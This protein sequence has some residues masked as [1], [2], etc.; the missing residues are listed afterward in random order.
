MLHLYLFLDEP[1]PRPLLSASPLAHGTALLMGIH[2][3]REE[4]EAHLQRLREQI[5]QALGGDGEC[6]SA[7]KPLAEPG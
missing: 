5:A 1:V 3:R 6:G 7:Q 2:D 4:A